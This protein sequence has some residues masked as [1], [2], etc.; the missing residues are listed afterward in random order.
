MKEG[1]MPQYSLVASDYDL[2]L[3]AL[4][5]ARM[6]ERVVQSLQRLLDAGVPVAVASGRGPAGILHNLK[7]H[8]L[9]GKGFFLCGYNG[10]EIVEVTS[11][12]EIASSRM[13]GELAR[14]IFRIAAQYPV[15][16]MAH[17]H[18]KVYSGNVEGF[19]A[20]TDAVVNGI[21]LFPI[22]ADG[23]RDL[24]PAKFLG[25]GKRADLERMAERLRSEFGPETEIVFSSDEL[26]EVNSA[27]IDKGWG[28]RQLA[29]AL[30]IPIE[31]T[32]AFGDNYNDLAMIQAAGL[33]V[34]MGN[35][36]PEVLAAADRVAPTCYDDGFAAV[37]DELF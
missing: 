26:L 3:A 18:G 33:G 5:G 11:G 14:D 10:A 15:E 13:D 21:E 9:G 31:H 36:V 20:K 17:L 27:G 8:G 1:V 19:H 2:T 32:V 12:R 34:A 22:D 29:G 7:R 30:S 28:L 35:A 25:A 6:T 16:I 4:P 23:V 24:R 37:I